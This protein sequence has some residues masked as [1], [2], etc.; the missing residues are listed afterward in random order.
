MHARVS[1]P[2]AENAPPTIRSQWLLAGICWGFIPRW[3]LQGHR[4]VLLRV[5][6]SGKREGAVEDE[7]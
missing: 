4:S 2:R 5:D 6:S 1:E 7:D 3:V